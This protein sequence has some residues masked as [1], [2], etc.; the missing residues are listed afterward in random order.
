MESLVLL[1]SRSVLSLLLVII[2]TWCFSSFLLYGITYQL[3]AWITA[4]VSGIYVL[5]LTFV[6]EPPQVS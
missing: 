2:V 3:C 1:V 4:L 5:L 6:E